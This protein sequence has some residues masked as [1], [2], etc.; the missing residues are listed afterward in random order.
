MDVLHVTI[1]E[2]KLC[3][4]CH[5]FRLLCFISLI[6]F[7][8]NRLTLLHFFFYIF[9]FVHCGLIVTKLDQQNAHTLM[10]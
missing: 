9:Y 7:F 3:V 2:V 5:Q 6:R 10:F 4:P 8:T 1:T